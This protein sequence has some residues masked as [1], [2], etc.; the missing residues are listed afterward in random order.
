MKPLSSHGRLIVAEEP[1]FNPWAVGQPAVIL[2]GDTLAKYGDGGQIVAWDDLSGRDGSPSQA[3]AAQRPLAK[4]I[5][6]NW[7]ASF[8]GVDDRLDSAGLIWINNEAWTIFAVMQTTGDNIWMS[9]V[10]GFNHQIRI[11]QAGNVLSEFDGGLNPISAALPIARTDRNLVEYSQ[12]VTVNTPWFG[13]N[14]REISGSGNINAGL[15][16]NRIGTASGGGAAFTLGY[17]WYMVAY[18]FRLNDAQRKYIEGG[19]NKKYRLPAL[20]S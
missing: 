1:K 17:I 7:C 16:L 6:G 13:Q 19:L 5:N 15:V 3:T 18:A 10:T 20:W 2:D 9:D 12:V 8:D 14:G 4:V 11:G